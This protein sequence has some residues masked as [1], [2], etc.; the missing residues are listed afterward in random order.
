M[1][2][3]TMCQGVKR[4]NDHN[5]TQECPMK[6]NCYRYTATANEYRQSWFM[7]IPYDFETNKCSNFWDNK[8]YK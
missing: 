6:D 8:G 7:V 1:A 2:D 4:D 3:I 5:V